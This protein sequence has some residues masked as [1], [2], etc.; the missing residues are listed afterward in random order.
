M[1]VD[2]VKKIIKTISMVIIIMLIVTACGVKDLT[3]DHNINYAS[4]RS[5]L[6]VYFLNVGQADSILIKTP[7]DKSMLIDAGN[8]DDGDFVV[9]YIKKLGIHKLDV[10]IAT[11]PH[12]DHIGAMA[13]VIK[14]FDIGTF[15]M[16]YVS[17]NTKTFENMLKALEYEKVRAKYARGGVAINLSKDIDAEFLAP[18]NSKYDDLNNYSAVV[19]LIYKNISFLFEGDAERESEAEMLSRGYDLTANILKIGHHGSSSSSSNKFL[20]AVNPQ[21]AVIMVGKNNDYGHPN[22]ETIDKLNLRGIKILR[23]DRDGTIFMS[24]NGSK[25][26]VYTRQ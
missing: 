25:L 23:T 9:D 1:E 14:S 5:E 18:N 21:Y 3:V 6:K 16:P 26:N 19:K 24:T 4:T 10:V 7:D 13:Q 12:E 15:Y 20:D 11:H 2:N 8:R 22:K 17:N